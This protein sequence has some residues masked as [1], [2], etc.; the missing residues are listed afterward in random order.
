VVTVTKQWLQI[1]AIWVGVAVFAG[2]AV[3]SLEPTV[4][5]GSFSALAGASIALVSLEHLFSAKT[6]DTVRQQVYV[7]AGSAT[8]LG[9]A[10]R[11]H[12]A[13]LAAAKI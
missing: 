4:A 2:Y 9:L 13:V 11:S 12:P 3:L 7:A 10:T 6:K 5:F 1:S 8:I